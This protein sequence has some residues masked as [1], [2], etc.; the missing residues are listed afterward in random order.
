MPSA[1]IE[2]RREADV[3]HV[4][5]S[6]PW[7]LSAGVL[8]AFVV[9]LLYMRDS[10]IKILDVAP[11]LATAK[12]AIKKIVVNDAAAKKLGLTIPAEI[13]AQAKA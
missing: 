13:A 8:T 2:A 6:G 11:D 7:T 9:T 4:R 1:Q 3:L 10:V 12:V 5:F